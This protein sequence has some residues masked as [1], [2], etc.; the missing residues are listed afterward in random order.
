M[1][2][3]F[4]SRNNL[5]IKPGDAVTYKSRLYGE[6][7]GEVIKCTLKQVYAWA[8]GAGYTDK[9]TVARITV[10]VQPSETVRYGYAVSMRPDRVDAII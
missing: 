2:Y 5:P 9:K 8:P 3:P 4:L 1:N 10:R 6:V 7:F